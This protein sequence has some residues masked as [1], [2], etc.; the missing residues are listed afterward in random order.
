MA[1]ASTPGNKQ[2][3]ASPVHQRVV[4][5]VEQAKHA[6]IEQALFYSFPTTQPSCQSSRAAHVLRASKANTSNTEKQFTAN[7]QDNIQL[8]YTWRTSRIPAQPSAPWPPLPTLLSEAFSTEGI[9]AQNR[10]RKTATKP[11]AAA[12]VQTYVQTMS[13]REANNVLLCVR[14]LLPLVGAT[15]VHLLRKI[16]MC[17]H[18]V[19]AVPI[20]QTSQ[21]EGN[22]PKVCKQALKQGFGLNFYQCLSM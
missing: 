12:T 5:G 3:A 14:L 18:E 16:M 15:A 2:T 19:H 10:K 13:Q 6:S 9:P 4:L 1:A 22:G 11:A 17:V 21:L 7:T 8:G 20:F